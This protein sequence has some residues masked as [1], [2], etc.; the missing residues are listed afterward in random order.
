MRENTRCV[1]APA[2]GGFAAAV[3]ALE[4]A[5][6]P[7]NVAGQSFATGEAALA[8][9][10]LTF[11]RGGTHVVAPAGAV[12]VANVLG[13][14]GVSADFVDTADLTAVRQ[15]VRGHT[16]IIYAETLSDTG[17]ADLRGLYR[18]AREVGA[19]LVVDST[20]ATPIVCRPLEHGADLVLHSTGVLLGDREGGVVVGRNDLMYR[21]TKDLGAPMS[22]ADESSLLSGLGTLTLRVRRRCATAMEF[23][24]AVAKHP[25]LVA[26]GYPGL[27]RDPGHHLARQLF[28]SG[29]EGTRFGPRVIVTPRG[30]ADDLIKSLRVIGDSTSAV[31][32]GKAVRF[33]IGFEDVEDLVT[34]VTR[35]LDSQAG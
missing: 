28:D 11:L 35:A 31:R 27:P 26:V 12:F 30:D 21:L 23:A 15:A 25:S 29:P 5:A 4:G 10:L 22:P 34:D 24:A 8:A 14:F 13:R 3:A 18:L 20:L 32:Q 7:E 2:E 17:V 6:A 33:S 1:R 9:V 19:M 16:K